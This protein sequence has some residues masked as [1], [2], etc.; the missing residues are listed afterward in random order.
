MTLVKKIYQNINAHMEEMLESPLVKNY[1]SASAAYGKSRNFLVASAKGMVIGA[2]AGAVIAIGL[3]FL[4][5]LAPEFIGEEDT[6]RKSNGKEAA[7]A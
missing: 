4:S 2:A 5:A 6:K 3:W 7:N 1:I